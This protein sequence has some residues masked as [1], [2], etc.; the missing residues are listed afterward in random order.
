VK[1]TT[2]L[3]RNATTICFIVYENTPILSMFKPSSG[4]RTKVRDGIQKE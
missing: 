1:D 4:C 3:F 2:I